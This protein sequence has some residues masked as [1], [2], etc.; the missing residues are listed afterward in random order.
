MLHT[1]GRVRKAGPCV[2]GHCNFRKSGPLLWWL[3]VFKE[4]GG[5]VDDTA[6]V[7][8]APGSRP[9]LALP[10]GILPI[11]VNDLAASACPA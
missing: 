11:T 10:G 7:V 1:Q 8:T 2:N 4:A 5:S 3:P 6:V 9:A